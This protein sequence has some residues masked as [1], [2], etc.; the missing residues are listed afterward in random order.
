MLMFVIVA[1]EAAHRQRHSGRGV[2]G[3]EHALLARHDRL[4]LPA[5]LHRRSARHARGR[6]RL[7]RATL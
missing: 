3:G 5:R 7:S 6:V 4:P 1:A 2:P